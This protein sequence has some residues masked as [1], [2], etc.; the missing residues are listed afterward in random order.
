MSCVKRYDQRHEVGPIHLDG[1]HF[2]ACLPV[3]FNSWRYRLPRSV[4]PHPRRLPR[5]APT[6][7]SSERSGCA[8]THLL[9]WLAGQ[10]RDPGARCD[11]DSP[12]YDRQHAGGRTDLRTTGRD[13]GR[14][15]AHAC[16]AWASD[17]RVVH[18]LLYDFCSRLLAGGM[19]TATHPGRDRTLCMLRLRPA[20]H[21][22]SMSGVWQ[23]T[24]G[25]RLD[26]HR[27]D[28]G[29]DCAAHQ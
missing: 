12:S 6:G 10:A 3:C 14:F 25:R 8:R 23:S 21:A 19:A 20:S 26:V 18:V 29:N 13:D 4:G 16:V 2:V 28:T 5:A 7:C 15:D 11:T 17:Q 27:A 9:D 24:V 22:Q 1:G